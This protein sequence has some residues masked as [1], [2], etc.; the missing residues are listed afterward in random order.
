MKDP[1]FLPG[2]SLDG[3]CLLRLWLEVHRRY[4]NYLLGLELAVVGTSGTNVL[5]IDAARAPCHVTSND[6]VIRSNSE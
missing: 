1:F 2:Q 3:R 5:V 4:G 6:Q